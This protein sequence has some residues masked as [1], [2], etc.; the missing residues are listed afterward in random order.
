MAN[1]CSH[2][3]EKDFRFTL[4]G[5]ALLIGW[6]SA[7]F[8]L[9]Q[10]PTASPTTQNQVLEEFVRIFF[11][12]F[13]NW[14]LVALGG[15]IYGVHLAETSQMKSFHRRN[16]FALI[17][18]SFLIILNKISVVFLVFTIMGPLLIH[19]KSLRPVYLISLTLL[20]YL[21]ASLLSINSFHYPF[22]EPFFYNLI[23]CT[24][25]TPIQLLQFLYKPETLMAFSYGFSLITAGML[26]QQM[27]WLSDYHFYYREMAVYIKITLLVL[28]VWAALLYF[29]IYDLMS[30]MVIGHLFQVMDSLVVNLI[31]LFILVFGLISAE[32]S[33]LGKRLL[34]LFQASGKAWH[35]QLILILVVMSFILTHPYSFK[36]RLIPLLL[37]IGAF[38]CC[39]LISIVLQKP[40]SRFFTDKEYKNQSPDSNKQ[41]KVQ[42]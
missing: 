4:K 11:T 39:S 19:L 7:G 33:R 18:F 1:T 36:N 5:L 24:T 35:F 14:K 3:A 23:S 13:V 12:Y 32:N 21:I 28:I 34:Q 8:I 27:N 15:F 40:Y 42:E 22:H 37:P 2:K 26:V 29:G 9:M 20:F 31:V 41:A 6:F 10:K 17:A 38:L 25:C 30:N 16:L